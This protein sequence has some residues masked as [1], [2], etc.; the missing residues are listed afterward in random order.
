MLA[1]AVNKVSPS[2]PVECPECHRGNKSSAKFCRACGS[3]LVAEEP[4]PA[5]SAP[6]ADASASAPFGTT[7]PQSGSGRAPRL[8]LAGVIAF[9][10]IVMAIAVSIELQENLPPAPQVAAVP[11]VVEQVPETADEAESG[12]IRMPGGRSPENAEAPPAAARPDE[13]PAI[14]AD[15]PEPGREPQ[16]HEAP[17]RTVGPARQQTD[18]FDGFTGRLIRNRSW[19]GVPVGTT[20]RIVG[21][22]GLTALIDWDLPR[23]QKSAVRSTLNVADVNRHFESAAPHP[24]QQQAGDGPIRQGDTLPHPSAKPSLPA[25]MIG[26]KVRVIIDGFEMPAGT[27][28]TVYNDSDGRLFIRWSGTSESSI[29]SKRG[30][31]VLVAVVDR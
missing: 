31:G 29:I 17:A 21:T 24:I 7:V 26:Y 5:D 30:V 14:S 18:S 25:N 27:V 20:G 11:R 1:E 6:A 19:S 13:R 9:V 12:E 15:G 16:V 8:L 28:G 2:T 23:D 10:L 4:P 3:R 22:S